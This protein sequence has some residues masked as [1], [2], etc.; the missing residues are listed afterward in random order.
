MPVPKM[1]KASTQ[2]VLA[3]VESDEC[4]ESD[5]GAKGRRFGAPY[6]WAGGID[7]MVVVA[8]NDEVALR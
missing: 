4:G 7:A 3:G 1:T 6:L 5:L 8:L 2:P